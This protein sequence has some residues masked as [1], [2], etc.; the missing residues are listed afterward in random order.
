LEH[1]LD[2]IIWDLA[3]VG[4]QRVACI[5]AQINGATP[6]YR[7]IVSL[8]RQRNSD[9]FNRLADKVN[10]LM[11]KTFEPTE[12]RNRIVHDPWYI[13]Y[14]KL[15]AQFGAMPIKDPRLGVCEI[16]AN[17]IEEVIKTA[18]NLADRAD[19]L[20]RPSTLRPRPMLDSLPIS[21]S[22]PCRRRQNA[23]AGRWAG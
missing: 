6:R 17:K 8:L 5:T 1:V 23:G 3:G 18:N 20:P 19:A 14:E 16:V 10:E 7:A 22:Q 2:L 13:T 9:R 21:A 15:P 4:E 12:Q 11:Q